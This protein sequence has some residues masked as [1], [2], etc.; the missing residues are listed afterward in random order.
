MGNRPLDWIRRQTTA[1]DL[2]DDGVENFSD[3]RGTDAAPLETETPLNPTHLQIRDQTLGRLRAERTQLERTT[4]RRAYS[5]FGLALGLAIALGGLVLTLYPVDMLVHHARARYLRS[6][7]EHV[8]PATSRFYGIS[9]IV[10]GLALVI[11]SAHRP[12]KQ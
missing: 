2:L 10:C 5:V 6:V 7:A 4:F 12:R 8:T 11:Y 1:D 3:L 9:L